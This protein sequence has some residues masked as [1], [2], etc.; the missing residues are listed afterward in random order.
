MA[1]TIN[2]G[3]ANSPKLTANIADHADVFGGR[4]LVFD[5]VV[6][7][8]N[9]D[10]IEIEN[11]FTISGWFKRQSLVTNYIFGHDGNNYIR[12]HGHDR[13]FIRIYGQDYF[14]DTVAIPFT[15]GDWFHLAITRDSN[16]LMK[17][18]F[19]GEK[20]SEEETSADNVFKTDYIGGS[21]DA[22][23][24]PY[25]GSMADVKFFDA[26]LTEAQVTELYRKPENTPSAVQDNLVAWY[27]MIE[28]NPESP[29]STVFDHSKKGLGSE[30]MSDGNFDSGISDF[31]SNDTGWVY[32]DNA[33]GIVDGSATTGIF[34]RANKSSGTIVAGGLYKVQFTVVEESGGNLRVRVGAGSFT[35]IYDSG[36]YTEYII[37]GS[38]TVEAINFYAEGN[39]QGYIDNVS[40]KKVLMGNH[41]TTNFFGDDLQTG[42]WN[43]SDLVG[44]TGASA[45]GFTAV[46]TD[47]SVGNDDN[48]YGD[49]IS[50]VAGKTYQMSF[51]LAI[52][53]GS[54]GSIFVGVTSGTAGSADSILSYT[55]ISSANNYSYTFTPTST[56]TRR[57][58]FRFVVNG[59]YNFTISNFEIKEVGI[60]SSGFE[61][62]VN[63]PVVPQVPLMRYNQKMLFDGIDDK[64]DLSTSSPRLG[65]S[66]FSISF[67]L[68]TLTALTDK[69]LFGSDNSSTT[70]WSVHGEGT[71][72]LR[73]NG[74]LTATSSALPSSATFNDGKLRHI[75]ISADRSGNLIYYVDG[76]LLSS[77]DISSDS[78]V[79]LKSIRYIGT[80]GAGT[81][82]F[83]QI[84]IFDDFSLWNYA[85][86]ATQVQELFNDGV[87][88]D[89]TTH[90]KSGNLLGY[91]RNDGVST[92][93]DRRGWS[94]LTFDSTDYI[95]CGTAIG[96]SLGDSYSNDL[97]ISAWFKL[98][99]TGTTRGIFEIGDF[100]GSHGQINLWYSSAGNL[101]FRLDGGN[102]TAF[103][104]FSDL[105][106][107]HVVAVYD[108][109]S[110]SNSK[111][112][113]NG[114]D[115]GTGSGTFPNSLDLS[116][117]KAI[118]GAI[119]SSS[120][121]WEGDIKSIGLYNVAKSQSEIEA[122]YNA[123]INSSE[124][125]NSGII[126]YWE[127]NNASSVKDL[128]G[129]SDGTING[130]LV[131]NDG[132]DG[133][134]AG[135]PDSITIREG[136][137][138]NRDGLGFYFET[139]T[140]NVLRLNA[141]IDGE[142]LVIPHTKSLSIGAD[143]TLEAWV[144]LK[145]L[146]D[147]RGIISKRSDTNVNYS[148][149]VTITGSDDGKLGS[150]DGSSEVISN[151][152]I[153]DN[154]WHHVAQVHSGTT[155]TFYIDGSASGGGTQSNFAENTHPVEIG[156]ARTDSNDLWDG[157]IDEIRIYNRALSASEISTNYKAGKGSHKNS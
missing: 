155:T 128:V 99:S 36:T 57:P 18:Y 83:A 48:A 44:F 127:L 58:S 101:A 54:I 68:C 132:N 139:D 79:N 3:Y 32:R 117:K 102:W 123:G 106:W 116:G 24:N 19:N 91:W 59:T 70:Q 82:A 2:S 136:L 143:F 97:T 115:L 8:L 31:T 49:E 1:A 56:V 93:Q 50:F 92:W 20:H 27:P 63:E 21:Y 81:S 11:D 61:T 133:T 144:K 28:S 10:T 13:L 105:G 103:K 156:S 88:Y 146:S 140:N 47:A 76:V 89:A 9:I 75:V 23:H 37:A 130:T 154:N 124:V 129:S 66:D 148:F 33:L 6:D 153:N 104:S 121:N 35:Y 152:T 14:G 87:A 51:T 46:N 38:S 84:N 118:I 42:T 78:A 4:A 131:L 112:Y 100:S 98:A 17:L 53:S 147:Y 119:L 145:D 45:D 126:N 109:S 122:I 90:S 16:N 137:N 110:E 22:S 34:A 96:T 142:K 138:S 60:S 55:L 29:Q 71:T 151:A 134:V 77:H 125:S 26:Q 67:W 141:F 120:F 80:Y 39:W 12:F 65:T 52:N 62:A 30:I 114:V 135:S 108:A 85:L 64:V 113:L 72:Q 73:W 69:R 95:D 74:G 157:L 150:F 7:K 149:F 40:V 107:N 86:S 111:L 15:I 43:N 41:A 94:A 25:Y 5:G